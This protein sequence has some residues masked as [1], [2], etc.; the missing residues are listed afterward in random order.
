MSEDRKTSQANT[1]HN[2]KSHRKN[3]FAVLP[4]IVTP[5]IFVLISLIAVVPACVHMM[6]MAIDT[7]HTAQETLSIGLNDVEA[8][9]EYSGVQTD[10]KA[11]KPSDISK[12]GEIICENAGLKA[13]AYYGINRV[14]LRNGAGV[15]SEA[16]LP[17]DNGVVN[18]YGYASDS[19]KALKYV[20]AGDIITFETGWGVYYYE[21]TDVST[22]EEA[23]VLTADQGLV[24]A[25]AKNNDAFSCFDDAK[26]YV[27]AELISEAS[28]EEVQ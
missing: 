4:Y 5:I 18:V 13:D 15:S 14:S 23:P 9:N 1:E 11:S 10:G 26:L 12:F 28:E 21:V 27:V 25:S 24:L 6:N 3:H 16:A 19:F 2:R 7:V 8:K 20:E 17:G 22:S